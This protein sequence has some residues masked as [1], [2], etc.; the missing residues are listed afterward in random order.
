[1]GLERRAG[2]PTGVAVAGGAVARKTTQQA[3]F[4]FSFFIFNWD[5]KWALCP[6]QQAYF[7]FANSALTGGSHPSD[8]VSFRF[9]FT[10]SANCKQL[11]KISWC[12]AIET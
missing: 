4:S 11:P 8:S 9:Q 1:M 7:F 3:Y 12:F 10:I 6:C 2:R 5:D